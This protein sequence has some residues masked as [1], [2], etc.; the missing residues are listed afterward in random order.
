L[1]KH[2]LSLFLHT[3][4]TGPGDATKVFHLVGLPPALKGGT[5]KIKLQ[6]QSGTFV[7]HSDLLTLNEAFYWNEGNLVK[8]IDEPLLSEKKLHL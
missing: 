4:K 2:R 5:F 7:G 8:I 1:K 6:F 3:Y